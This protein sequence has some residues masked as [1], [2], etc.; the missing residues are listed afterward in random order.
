MASFIKVN[1]PI[2]HG[3]IV[4][5]D[6]KRFQEYVGSFIEFKLLPYGDYMVVAENQKGLPKNQTASALAGF[7]ICGDAVLCK[8]LE[9]E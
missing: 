5:I 4:P 2:Q 8:P 1:G 9:I 3:L 6:L 7:R